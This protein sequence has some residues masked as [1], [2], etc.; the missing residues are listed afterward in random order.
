[1]KDLKLTLAMSSGDDTWVMGKDPES[2]FA[3]SCIEGGKDAEAIG[4]ERARGMFIRTG[5][6][7]LCD[8]AYGNSS[9]SGWWTDPA[10]GEDLLVA[11]GRWAPYV[12]GTKIALIHS[13]VS[14]GLEG[15]RKNRKDDH[16]PHR[17]Q[18]EV[19]LADTIIR[20]A[21]LAGKLDL[22]L[23]GAIVEKMAYNAA[24]ADHKP[25]ARA[26]EGGKQ[27]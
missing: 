13:E 25:E 4:D 9:G 16:L 5:I 23:A 3:G 24:R 21:D 10:T 11:A 1:M 27:F 22:D 18:L 19:E 12:I 20:I 2:G 15:Q 8:T 17:S 14:E 26:A 7:V 6:S